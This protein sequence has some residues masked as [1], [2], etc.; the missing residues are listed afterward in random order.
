[1][2]RTPLAASIAVGSLF[3]LLVSGWGDPGGSKHEGA[4]ESVANDLAR[5]E[6]AIAHSNRLDCHAA[7]DAVA[8]R[9]RTIAAPTVTG[10]GSV[11]LRLTPAYLE[12][13]LLDP[14]GVKAGSRM[15]NVPHGLPDAERAEAAKDLVHFLLTAPNTP[16]DPLLLAAF[17]EPTPILRGVPEEGARLYR[18]IGCAVCH[19]ETPEFERYARSTTVPAFAAMLREP[20]TIWASGHMPSMRLSEDEAIAITA[21]CLH[22]QAFGAQS[23]EAGTASPS[24]ETAL[25]AIAD[26]PVHR[27]PDLLAEF[28]EGAVPP[29]GP[30]LEGLVDR[31]FVAPRP[32]L[33]EQ[34]PPEMF[35]LRFKGSIEI[36]T[37]G[38]WT[39]FLTSDDGSRLYLDGALA[40]SPGRLGH[41]GPPPGET[42]SRSTRQIAATA[43][44]ALDPAPDA[45]GG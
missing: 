23:L 45:I 33:P 32:E 35:A 22:P 6:M 27:M 15:P 3:S 17:E 31:Q 7:S 28:V 40:V 43:D 19:G 29:S 11:A 1:M 42:A 14:A 20:T 4:V 8:S 10:N 24:H 36:P 44:R 26:A 37:A 9:E 25:A 34:H 38:A 5:G 39:F 18:T 30:G 2:P 41:A 13:C 16:K 21:W 12:R